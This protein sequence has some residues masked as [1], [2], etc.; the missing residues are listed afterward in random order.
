M[1][2]V[3]FISLGRSKFG[4]EIRIFGNRRNK[5][6]RELRGWWLSLLPLSIRTSQSD[7]LN[8]IVRG[9]KSGCGHGFGGG[10]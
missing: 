4:S 1:R 3:G 2:G 6:K 10:F 5:H 9:V 8:Q 7:Q